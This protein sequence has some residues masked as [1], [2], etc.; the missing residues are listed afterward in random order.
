[1]TVDD[2]TTMGQFQK[3]MYDLTNVRSEKQ[4][5]KHKRKE[6]VLAKQTPL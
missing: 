4:V 3:M 2:T 1:V 5:R 6:R